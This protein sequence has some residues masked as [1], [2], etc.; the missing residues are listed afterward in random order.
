MRSCQGR[1]IWILLAAVI[2]LLV[3][4]V[5]AGAIFFV[6]QRQQTTSAT[7]QDPIA[8]ILPAEILPE[9]ALYPLAGA[10]ELE[11]IDVAMANGDL[12]T[13]Y[14]ALVFSM[15]LT[16]VQRIGRLTLLGK[17]FVEADLPRRADLCYQQIY[18]VALISPTLNDP[19]RADALLGSGTGWAALG[20]TA[21]AA[22][23]CD[24]VYLL[25]TQSPYLQMAH[26]RDLLGRLETAYGDLGDVERAA[27]CQQAI[28][29]LDQQ[30][31]PQ[32]PAMPGP[33]PGLPQG[34][35]PVSSPQVG[36]LEEARRQAAY[37][38]LQA[39]GGEAEPP[40]GL[41]GNLAQALQAEDAAKQG[42]Y[43]QELDATSQPGKRI[44][45]DWQSIRW[46]MLKY[47][48]AARGFGLSLVPEWESQLP[49]IQSA[50]S[51]AYEDLL[52][53]YEDFVAALPD[54]SL[55]GS[56][57]YQARRQSILAGQ[58]GQYPNYPAEQLA[59]KLQDAATDLI[60]AGSREQLY[61]DV[62]VENGG[63]RFYLSPAEQY[64][65]PAQ[66]PQ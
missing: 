64:G 63:L 13:A 18:D 32:P 40:P 52:F 61:L 3:V 66:P 20:Q 43:Q 6:L 29:N 16:D 65:L 2:V 55:L 60:A 22:N 28:A 19:A 62:A 41:V 38:L 44:N 7:W 34:S 14:A 50:L 35:E 11:T 37:T 17:R 49:D 10:S 30:P 39:L 53:D 8:G 12:E 42:L 58:L 15:D 45:V 25:A 36:T 21:L 51:T 48:V 24:Q 23:A 5:V 57:S 33:A 54:A 47:R 27:A 4:A 9:L 46:L 56:G 31:N 59:S 26:R 1:L